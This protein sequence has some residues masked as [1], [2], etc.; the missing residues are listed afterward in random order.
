LQ[1]CL[2][3]IKFLLV[4]VLPMANVSQ[5]NNKQVTVKSKSFSDNNLST[6]SEINTQ[7]AWLI[8]N[9]Q[10]LADNV[11]KLKGLLSPSTQLMTVIK[12]DAYGHGAVKV[13]ETVLNHGASAL[14]VATLGEGIELRE[15]QI[16][17]P[18]LILGAINTA[19]EVKDLLNWQLEPTICSIQQGS[20]IAE[21]L[22]KLGANLGVHLKIDTGMSR[23]GTLWPETDDFVE[24][25][26][27]MPQLQIK[28]FYS[29]LATADDPNPIMMQ[30]QHQRFEECLKKLRGKNINIPCR[31][32]ANSA[33]TLSDRNL[34]YDL[35]RVGLALYGIYPAP[36]LRDK[37]ELKPVLEVKA[38]ITQIK[39][40]PPQT[41][42]SYGHTFIS[43]NFTKIAIVGIG[44]ADGVPRLLS[45]K[46]RVLIRGKFVNQ[47]GNITMDQL[48]LNVNDLPDLEVGEIVTL[49]GK[50]GNSSISAD[51]WAN[52]IGT[53]SWEILCGFKHRLPRIIKSNGQS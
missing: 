20:I 50:D 17:A 38:R 39:I 29:H 2:I 43:D 14:A 48:I 6:T 45:N 30:K 35:V 26:L 46:M 4:S 36:H 27:T 31:H 9:H 19:E 18:I 23:L 22:E 32:L 13:A 49:L 11:K 53:I 10:A 52:M 51:D 33:G 34:H 24:K 47:I 37:V 44:Y 3:N 5:N 8:I 40:I 42:V 16:K 28:S 15:A 41:G 25:I 7:R 12:A 1:S 21:A